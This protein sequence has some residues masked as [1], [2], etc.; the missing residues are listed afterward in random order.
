[1]QISF[2]PVI[3][4]SPNRTMRYS[5]AL[6][7]LILSVVCSD[8][9]QTFAIE[10]IL[11]S[12][13]GN[14]VAY[15]SMDDDNG[16]VGE[17]PKPKGLSLGNGVASLDTFS[18][19]NETLG[20]E[21]VWDGDVDLNGV[22]PKDSALSIEQ[23]FIRGSSSPDT[24]DGLK[25]TTEKKTRRHQLRRKASQCNMQCFRNRDCGG[26]CNRCSRSRSVFAC[27]SSLESDA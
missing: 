11:E 27:F 19:D 18:D 22:E 26:V 20:P 7:S 4:H 12:D 10:N 14:D 2:T 21:L 25:V 9:I 1:V 23:R 16:Q 8:M 5:N 6:A 15:Y 17:R 24:S 3:I 13:L